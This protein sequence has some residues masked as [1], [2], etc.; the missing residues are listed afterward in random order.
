MLPR[1]RKRGENLSEKDRKTI[2]GLYSWGYTTAKVIEIS[3][4]SAKA[5]RRWKKRKIEKNE[6][7]QGRKPKLGKRETRKVLKI[8]QENNRTGTKRLTPEINRVISVPISDRTVRRI[9]VREGSRWAYPQRETKFTNSQKVERVEWCLEH[10]TARVWK[11]AWLHDESYY[12]MDPHKYKSRIFPDDEKAKLQKQWKLLK[13]EAFVNREGKSKLYFWEG[14]RDQVHFRRHMRDIY[15]DDLKKL[16]RKLRVKLPSY[17]FDKASC[18]TAKRTQKFLN[19]R[20]LRWEFFCTKPCSINVI[21]QLWGIIKTETWKRKP[22]NMKEA[23]KY[24][25]EEWN[26]I[27]R[28]KLRNLFDSIPTRVRE[29]IQNGGGKTHYWTC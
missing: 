25:T 8:L 9:S 19:R 5:C 3:G 26:K 24:L 14:R 10:R 7:G 28:E 6:K 21:E 20:N 13:F 22:K 18:H 1:K 2:Q 15:L 11:G 23:Q 16:N 4:F 29:V 12:S 27:T 17:F